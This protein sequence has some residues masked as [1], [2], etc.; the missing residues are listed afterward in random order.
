MRASSFFALHAFDDLLYGLIYEGIFISES[1]A[2]FA[3]Q[4]FLAQMNP[5]MHS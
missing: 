2:V 3:R 4:P 1:V 5:A